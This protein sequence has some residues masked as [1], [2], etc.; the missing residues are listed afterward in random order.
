MSNSPV[1]RYIYNLLIDLLPKHQIR[2]TIVT[3]FNEVYYQCVRIQ[4]D[5]NPGDDVSHR[6]IDEEESWLGSHKAAMLVFCL[7]W[8][9]MERKK[10]VSFNEECFVNKLKPLLEDSEFVQVGKGLESFMQSENLYSPNRFRTKTCP[11]NDIPMR[12]DIEYN[13]SLPWWKRLFA[14]S[15][16]HVE[17]SPIDFNPWRKVTDNFSENTIKW[18]VELY[19]TREDQLRLLE[20]IEKACTKQEYKIHASF[21]RAQKMTIRGGFYVGASMS[22]PQVY[23]HSMYPH[24]AHDMQYVTAGEPDYPVSLSELY[25][26]KCEEADRRC[27]ELQK[28]QELEIARLEAK[29]ESEIEVLHQQLQQYT[30]DNPDIN[31]EEPKQNHE[32]ESPKDEIMIPI[33]KLADYVK[34]CFSKSGGAE[35]GIMLYH[36]AKDRGPI[37][38]K[39]AKLIDD[40]LPAIIERDKPHQTVEIP[41]AGQVNI[42]PQQVITQLKEEE[43]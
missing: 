19:S 12:I 27:E 42:S 11:V 8:P 28:S 41:H 35:V 37:D 43:K 5:G 7:A 16:L 3:L 15:L 6:Y 34:S 38:E 23:G 9:L 29:Y 4:F 36:F 21:F 32:D 14:S 31:V 13:M 20:R 10:Q 22:Y 26:Q 40:I 30:A 18:Y 33:G 39:T 2:V 25:K 1:N 17:S 24:S